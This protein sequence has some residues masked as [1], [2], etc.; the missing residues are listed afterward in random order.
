MEHNNHDHE[1]KHH[2]LPEKLAIKTGLALLFLTVVTVWSAHIDLGWFNFPLAM[3]IATT[4]ALLVILI[5]MGLKYDANDNRVIFATS[6][7]FLVIFIGLTATDVFYR[8]DVMVKGPLTAPSGGKSKFK[9]AWIATPE[10][11]KHGK[12]QFAAQ[13]VSCHGSEGRGDGAA[14][15][16]LNPKPRNFTLGDGWKIGR[17][18]SQVFKTLKEGVPGSAM[19]SYATLSTDDR[20]GLI[21]YVLSL[22]PT[23]PTDSNTDLAAIGIDPNKEDA[24]GSAD[25]SIPIEVAVAQLTQKDHEVV[26]VKASATNGSAHSSAAGLLYANRCAS[27]HGTHAQGGE[28][29]PG[30]GAPAFA[31]IPALTASLSQ[32]HFNQVVVKGL[33]GD[34]MP[35]NAALTGAQL[36][37]LYAHVKSLIS[38][39]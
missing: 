24:G 7:V 16:A 15:S 35:A 30:Y 28:R 4:K 38:S 3:I 36:R 20:W 19:G 2:I 13:C 21:H 34:L 33:Q 29:V 26:T 8:G 32:D 27:C 6:F 23:P 10:L 25:K 22:G 14:A 1:H 18:P 12:E 11:V 39:R 9:K 31:K 17:K 37:D 5:F